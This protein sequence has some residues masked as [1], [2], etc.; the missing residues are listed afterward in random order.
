MSTSGI[1]ENSAATPAKIDGP[2]IGVL[3]LLGLTGTPTEITHLERHLKRQGFRTEVPLLAGHGKTHD[4]LLA[5]TWEDWAES[6][7]PALRK[8]AA[9]CDHVF[10][11]GL[12]M[13]AMLAMVLAPEEPKVA[14]IVI[15][16]IEAGRFAKGTHRFGFM[17]P[18]GFL[19]PF[20]WQKNF[21]WTEHPPFGLKDPVLREEIEYRLSHS[22][23]GESEEHGTFRT[24]V[25]S[26]HQ[27]SR[28]RK[29]AF[30]FA[31]TL[32]C[33]A[34][35]L[36]SSE[37]TLTDPSNAQKTFAALGCPRKTLCLMSGTDH[38]MT[39]DLRKKD[40]ADQVTAFI[41]AEIRNLRT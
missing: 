25:P 10:I 7:R 37:D 29:R 36:Q 22:K 5:T 38:M 24:Y 26:F 30:H 12:C 6:A 8:L 3:L 11:A 20:K 1:A 39:I 33:S 2:K 32:R 41:R 23:S 14:G 18:V 15:I 19:L 17:L 27:L 31:P 35:I 21:Y 28:L 34:L 13:G 9:E 16:S 4:E 40:V